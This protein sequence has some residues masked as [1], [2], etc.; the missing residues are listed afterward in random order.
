MYSVL[1]VVWVVVFTPQLLD[2]PG[3]WHLPLAV[4]GAVGWV[5]LSAAFVAGAVAQRREEAG[6]AP[7]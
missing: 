1:G 4:A 5:L 7:S 6:N 3:G 2:G